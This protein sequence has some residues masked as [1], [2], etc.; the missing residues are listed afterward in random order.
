MDSAHHAGFEE[1][2]RRS[3]RSK[4]ASGLKK[5]KKARQEIL[6]AEPPERNTA[7]LLVSY[8]FGKSFLCGLKIS[9]PQVS[10]VWK[11]VPCF[12]AVLHSIPVPPLALGAAGVGMAHDSA[13]KTGTSATQFLD[14]G[15]RTAP[16]NETLFSREAQEPEFGTSTPTYC[17]AHLP[18]L[19][20]ETPHGWCLSGIST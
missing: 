3:H 14:F 2:G 10:F 7:W 18:V 11:H 17:I 19:L 5:G 12:P 16:E 13:R 15:G 1:G 9:V 20:R 4:N 8:H 6:F